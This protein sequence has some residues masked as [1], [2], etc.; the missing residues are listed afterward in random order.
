MFANRHCKLRGH[1]K[2][3]TTKTEQSLRKGKSFLDTINIRKSLY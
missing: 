2:D 1:P 3:K